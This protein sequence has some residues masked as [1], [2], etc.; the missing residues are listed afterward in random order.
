MRLGAK[1]GL[2]V[3]Y[4]P[5]HMES[6]LE[7]GCRSVELFLSAIPV[8]GVC[9]T[10]HAVPVISRMGTSLLEDGTDMEPEQQLVRKRGM[11]K[12]A[13]KRLSALNASHAS[14]RKAHVRRLAGGGRSLP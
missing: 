3:L 9:N 2:P 5:R 12:K 8:M 4:S 7:D 11:S 10:P 6:S 13:M 1:L 14:A